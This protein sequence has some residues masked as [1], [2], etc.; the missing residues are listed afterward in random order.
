M[1]CVLTLKQPQPKL[2]A[3]VYAVARACEVPFDADGCHFILSCTLK[4][5]CEVYVA[6][7]G[8][9]WERPITTIS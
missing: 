3:Q 2:Q 9:C 4:V 1:K 6:N 7:K 5:F 8:P